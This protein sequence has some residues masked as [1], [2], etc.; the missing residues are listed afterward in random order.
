MCLT[1]MF[2]INW[3]RVRERE[4]KKIECGL[5][6]GI[7][8][9]IFLEETTTLQQRGSLPMVAQDVTHDYPIHANKRAKNVNKP[10]WLREKFKGYVCG[11]VL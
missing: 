3:E 2:P 6:K 1:E 9:I 10:P 11:V 8:G 7:V 4:R 5:V